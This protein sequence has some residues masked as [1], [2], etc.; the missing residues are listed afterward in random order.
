VRLLFKQSM[1]NTA[2]CINVCYSLQ[3]L[4]PTFFCLLVH[5][6]IFKNVFISSHYV[7]VF[8]IE[9]CEN[10]YQFQ[11]GINDFFFH[12]VSRSAWGP[13]SL[14]SYG[15]GAIAPGI[16]R[17]E[18]KTDHSY[19]SSVEVQNTWSYVSTPPYV[20]IAWCLMN[21]KDNTIFSTSRRVSLGCS[22]PS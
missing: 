7:R 16:K 20:F 10:G 17:P 14:L 2:N 6:R 8:L 19:P 11:A 15:Y 4:P 21:H 22:W 18:R 9:L 3:L 1:L 5:W 12:T 13:P